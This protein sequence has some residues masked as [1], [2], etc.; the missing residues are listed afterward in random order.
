[1]I[2]LHKMCSV[3]SKYKWKS[4]VSKKK[5]SKIISWRAK[6]MNILLIM[7]KIENIIKQYPL[8]MHMPINILKA[9]QNFTKIFNE[10]LISIF[11]NNF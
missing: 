6:N 10:Q 5:L 4:W 7:V 11:C 9:F 2:T 8:K 1:M 3:K